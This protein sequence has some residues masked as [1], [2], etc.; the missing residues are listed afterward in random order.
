MEIQQPKKKMS[1]KLEALIR[2]GIIWVL[3]DIAYR[4][5]TFI[6]YVMLFSAEINT[7]IEYYENLVFPRNVTI[8]TSLISMPLFA[9]F[10]TYMRGRTEGDRR[11]MLVGDV[12]DGNY[13]L[14]SH[15]K[16]NYLAEILVFVGIHVV[17]QL[18]FCAFYA[19]FGFK[20]DDTQTIIEKIHVADSAFYLMTKIPIL[21][22]L[23]NAIYTFIC[24][25][26]SRLV[27]LVHWRR[28]DT[29]FV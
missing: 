21:G 17:F 19:F 20:F 28:D 25:A 13:T 14:L 29:N 24:L 8:I 5:V 7:V 12:K 27:G 18:V 6:I 1:P 11:R 10:Y 3:C 26:V 2:A 23:L 9:V 15:F 16:K 4:I 22:L